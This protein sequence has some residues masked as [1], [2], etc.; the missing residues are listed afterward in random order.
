MPG[1]DAWAPSEM[2]A[3]VL[4]AVVYRAGMGG[5][6]AEVAFAL[7]VDEQRMRA[8]GEILRRLLKLT[9]TTVW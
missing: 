4:R 6:Y 5:G 1:R 9:T 8:A 7:G 2:A 3:A